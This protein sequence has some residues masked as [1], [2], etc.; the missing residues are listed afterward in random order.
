MPPPGLHLFQSKSLDSHCTNAPF[1]MLWLFATAGNHCD[2]PLLVIQFSIEHALS[3]PKG[4]FSSVRH[5]EIRDL[6]LY[7]SR[8]TIVARLAV[9]RISVSFCVFF[10]KWPTASIRPFKHFIQVS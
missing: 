5:N 2:L 6:T 1:K 7:R 10:Y 4:G 8:A 9:V 3:C